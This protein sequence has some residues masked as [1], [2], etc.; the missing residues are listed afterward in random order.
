MRICIAF[1]APDNNKHRTITTDRGEK[2][3]QLGSGKTI[4]DCGGES[5]ITIPNCDISMMQWYGNRWP[6][7]SSWMRNKRSPRS[8]TTAY[9]ASSGNPRSNCILRF[10]GSKSEKRNKRSR[11][12]RVSANVRVVADCQYTLIFHYLLSKED[13]EAPSGLQAGSQLVG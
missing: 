1:H 8:R 5:N 6:N 12:H 9:I 13:H 4:L 10:P 7:T 2:K 3:E 11:T